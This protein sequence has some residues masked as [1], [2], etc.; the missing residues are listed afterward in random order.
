[1]ARPNRK[2]RE[3]LKAPKYL[4][5]VQHWLASGMFQAGQVYVAEVLH[6]DSCPMP[7]GAGPCSCT[8]AVRPP[9]PL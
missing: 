8:P 9:R 5:A 3:Q 7:A 1:M 4:A 2:R 6:A